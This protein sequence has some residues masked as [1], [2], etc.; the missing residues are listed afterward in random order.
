M[1]DQKLLLSTAGTDCAPAYAG[2]H[3]VARTQRPSPKSKDPASH[4]PAKPLILCPDCDLEMRL[5]GIEPER[6]TRDLYTFECV[7]CRRLEVRGVLVL[8]A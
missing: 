8:V 2:G 3:R 1:M 5:F 6:E 7:G 4:E